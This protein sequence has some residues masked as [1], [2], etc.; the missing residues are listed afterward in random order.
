[1]RLQ[2]AEIVACLSLFGGSTVFIDIF[3]EFSKRLGKSSDQ[4]P[5]PEAISLT[6]VPLPPGTLNTSV[7]GCTADL[8]PRRTGCIALDGTS[9]GDFLADGIH[10]VASVNFVGA[11]TAPDPAS[12]YTGLQLILLK[13]DGTTFSNGDSW[14][15]ITCGVTATDKVGSTALTPYPQA[16]HDGVRLLAGTN[17]VDC[18][19]NQLVS[20]SCTPDKVH[21]YPVR[22]SNTANDSGAG[23]GGS[24][25]ELRLH[26]DQVHLLFNSFVPSRGS[27]GEIGLIARLKFNETGTNGSNPRYDLTNV[28]LLLN[29]N[30]PQPISTWGNELVINSSSL[31]VGELRGFTGSGKEVVYVGYPV[32]SCNL[33][34]FAADLTTGAVRRLTA[35]PEYA[36]PIAVSPDDKWQVVLDT[37]GTNRQMFLAG[38][39]TVPPITDLVSV[40]ASSSTRN[41]GNRRFFEPWL[42]DHDGDRGLYF[43]QKIS[44]VGDGSPGSFNDPNWNALADP[45]WSPD[46]TR[47]VYYQTLAVSPACGG[48]NPLPC[49]NST[50]PYGS[51]DR[52]IVAHLASRTPLSITP[53]EE[54]PDVIPWAVPYAPGMIIPERPLPAAGE[55][56]LFGANEGY[57]NVTIGYDSTNTFIQ[58]VNATYH[59]FSNDGINVLVG[60]E[61]VSVTP[62]NATNSLY[63][64]YSDLTSSGVA[65]GSKKTTPGGFHLTIDV[66]TNIFEATGNLTTTINGVSFYQPL[67]NA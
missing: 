60:Y 21:I 62:K 31:Q 66:L 34:L 67:N 41:N 8:N 30:L 28:N 42:I 7:G 5:S 27:L 36:D 25:R 16:F 50:E 59:N 64:W 49:E 52:V 19:G 15:C 9:A 37:R 47:I 2:I 54:L 38:L 14:K 6:K 45:R 39:R 23:A 63:D 65:T 10:V 24:I 13:I 17:V 32:E 22:W 61:S 57:A 4:P 12:I 20:D 3:I 55:Y 53:V 18:G 48:T 11:P 35:H 58:T 40:S 33:D 43:G 1:M 44:E 51:L 56:T 26:P 46:G 29:P